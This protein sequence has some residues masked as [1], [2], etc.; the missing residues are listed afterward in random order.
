MAVSWTTFW[1]IPEILGSLFLTAITRYLGITGISLD[2][3]PVVESDIV[4]VVV[5]KPEPSK[6]KYRKNITES[7]W[8]SKILVQLILSSISNWLK[9]VLVIF[10]AR[11]GWYNTFASLRA[12]DKLNLTCC[13]LCQRDKLLPIKAIPWIKSSTLLLNNANI[14]WM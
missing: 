5:V 10:S 13:K 9:F 11:S 4:V 12:F 6:S 1:I 2:D 14:I 3:C 8:V 7:L